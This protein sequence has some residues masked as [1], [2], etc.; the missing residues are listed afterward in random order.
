MTWYKYNPVVHIH[1][2]FRKYCGKGNA[3]EEYL[4]TF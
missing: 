4:F 1:S 3:T 2:K